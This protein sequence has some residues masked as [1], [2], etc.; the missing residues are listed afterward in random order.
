MKTMVNK[1]CGD[2]LCDFWVEV[3]RINRGARQIVDF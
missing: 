2:I 3:L 1:M